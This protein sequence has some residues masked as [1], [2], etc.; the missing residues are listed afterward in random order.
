[1]SA[2]RQALE[3]LNGSLQNL[4][5]SVGGFEQSMAGAQRD[6]FGGPDVPAHQPS[7]Q[8][9]LDINLMAKR[10]DNAIDKVEE[11]LSESA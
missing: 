8:N 1:M 5:N 2:I 10:L 6:M 3:Q 4:E 7:N 9:D 11:I